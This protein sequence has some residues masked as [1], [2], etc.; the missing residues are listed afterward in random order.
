MKIA[1]SSD[2]HG[3]FD[4]KWPKAD[5]LILGGDICSNHSN[6]RAT[7]AF[8]QSLW[9]ESTLMPTLAKLIESK[10]YKDIVIIAGNHDK[11]FAYEQERALDA[12]HSVP[13]IHYLQDEGVK[14]ENKLF[15]GSPWT[16]WFYGNHWVFNLP[17]PLENPARARAH[18]RS[19]WE[20]I[21]TETDVLITHGPPY[22]IMD[23]CADG[24]TVG[25]P[26][27]AEEVFKRIRPSLHMFGH[28]HEGRGM[29]VRD[30]IT[31]VNAAICT[32]EYKPTNEIQVVEI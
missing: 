14:I 18:A 32:L 20:L 23:E 4:I 26:H 6:M 16:P 8:I 28:I 22:S 1:C 10:T 30:G 29:C 21:P 7:D 27:L 15:W 25:C 17:D 11:V 5:V 13:N 2:L 9:I 24:R 31:F 12:I 3:R 19:I